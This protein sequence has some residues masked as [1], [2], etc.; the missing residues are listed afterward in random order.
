MKESTSTPGRSEDGHR[1]APDRTCPT[2]DLAGAEAPT[3]RRR[4][5]VLRLKARGEDFKIVQLV[6]QLFVCTKANG[7][8]CC[9][10]SVKGRMPFDNTLW[11][12]EWERRR[13]RDRVHLSF[14]GCLGPCLVGNNALLVLFGQTIWLKDLND[15]S[16]APA[17]WDWV[18]AMLEAGAVLPPPAALADHVWDRYRPAAPG[19]ALPMFEAAPEEAAEDA[20][21]G[22]DPVCLMAVD[23]GTARHRVEHDGRTYA[24]CAPACKK[25][26]LADPESYLS[27]ASRR[28]V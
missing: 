24:F 10:W 22:L 28:A 23:V 4:L 25:L 3:A 8:C 26:F 12:D 15:S 1:H 14:V 16:L 2:C 9:G 5:S 11:S 6:G 18:E 19:S 21:D 7:S 27:G 17:V 13:I 20:L